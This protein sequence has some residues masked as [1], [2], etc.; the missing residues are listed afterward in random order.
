MLEGFSAISQNAGQAGLILAWAASLRA[1][2]D[3][4]GL[5]DPVIGDPSQ[6]LP[7]PFEYPVCFGGGRRNSAGEDFAQGD[8][9]YSDLSQLRGLDAGKFRCIPEFLFERSASVLKPSPLLLNAYSL[10]VSNKYVAAF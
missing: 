3:D 7:S 4:A 10:R 1:A 9:S 8:E 2:E 5:P 6:H